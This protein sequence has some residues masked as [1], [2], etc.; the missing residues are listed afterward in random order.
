MKFDEKDMSE[1]FEDSLD[2]GEVGINIMADVGSGFVTVNLGTKVQFLSFDK[3]E[4]MYIDE[5]IIKA[6]KQLPDRPMA[7][8]DPPN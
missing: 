2:R 7:E 4:A 8:L 3:I 1:S 5:E 6:A